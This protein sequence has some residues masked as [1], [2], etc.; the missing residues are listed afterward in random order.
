LVSVCNLKIKLGSK[1]IN[2]R[3]NKLKGGL[4]R[5]SRCFVGYYLEEIG[6]VDDD[7]YYGKISGL[8]I[9]FSSSTSSV[10][11]PRDDYQNENRRQ[12]S[13]PRITFDRLH[14]IQCMINF[15]THLPADHHP[16]INSENNSSCYY[17]FF[18]GIKDNNQGRTP[19]PSDYM[20]Q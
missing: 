3:L 11:F 20:I 8:F 2:N 17:A 9:D 5:S 16:Q 10:L 12:A 14:C 1:L 19:A 15:I 13:I 18:Q 7:G 6:I 4:Q